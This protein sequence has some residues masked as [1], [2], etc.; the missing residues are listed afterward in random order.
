MGNEIE[1]AFRSTSAVLLGRRLSGL[2]AYGE[3]LERHTLKPMRVES[4]VSG[5]VIYAENMPY[6]HEIGKRIASMEEVLGLDK[7]ITHAEL[8]ML[9]IDN[10]AEILKGAKTISVDWA[11]GSNIDMVECPL[12]GNSAHCFRATACFKSKFC[13]YSFW[14][15]QSEYVFGCSYAFSSKFCMNCYFSVNLTR[16]FE[17]SDCDSC[18]DSYFCHNCE[19]LRECMLCFNAKSLQYA[20]GNVELGKEEYMKVKRMVLG[21]IAERLE[22]EK[23]FDV[24]IYNIGCYKSK[25]N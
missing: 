20:I 16:C 7:S 23:K 1:E 9:R 3:W 18:S 15:R 13:A 4:A 17:M 22:K 2:E 5:K 24:D 10:A 8:D 12:Y 14:P 6:N 25:K 21:Q 19:G 11:I